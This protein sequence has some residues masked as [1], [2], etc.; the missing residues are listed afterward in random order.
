MIILVL[1]FIDQ[2]SAD[3]VKHQLC[4]LN[5][6]INADLQPVFTSH[7]L[8]NVLKI[9]EQ[10]PPLVNQQLVVYYYKCGSCDADYVGY[11][12]RH[13]HQ[14]KKEHQHS[15]IGKHQWEKHGLQNKIQD[16]CFTILKKCKTKFDCLIY[17]MMFIKEKSPSH[18]TQADSVKAKLFT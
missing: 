15:A 12:A 9:Q 1:P 8:E 18:D 14:R 6:K 17:G 7:K 2:K 5:K 3:S 16:Q 4:H 13:L 10:K 11:T